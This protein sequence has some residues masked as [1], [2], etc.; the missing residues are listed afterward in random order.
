MLYVGDTLYEY[1]NIIFPN[2]GS[3]VTWFSTVD[4]LISFVQ[5]HSEAS[6]ECPAALVDVRINCGHATACG[7]ALEVLQLTRD[8]MMDVVSGREKV[9][10]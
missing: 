5:S 3:I 10:S 9:Q 7:P 2:E 1:D 4:Y 8:F 6:R